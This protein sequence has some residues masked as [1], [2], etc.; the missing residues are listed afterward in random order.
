[1]VWHPSTR[2]RCGHPGHGTT[3]TVRARVSAERAVHP[4]T[5]RSSPSGPRRQRDGR[6]HRSGYASGWV[7]GRVEAGGRMLT[8]RGWG[9]VL[10]GPDVCRG[11]ASLAAAARRGAFL[12]ATRGVIDPGGQ[13]VSA[14]DPLPMGIEIP[15]LIVWGTRD[16]MIP[17]W[18]ATA[19]HQAI[20]DS[21]VVLFEGAGHFPHL[22]EPERFDQVLGDF[23]AR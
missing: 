17:A 6:P 23:M 19:G 18:H 16:R 1:M 11:F 9:G 20:A 14:H 15:T 22:D 8:S 13:T 7:R 10:D 4:C 12:A 5:S 2:A 3:S 21:R